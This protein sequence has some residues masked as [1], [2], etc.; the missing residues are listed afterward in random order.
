MGASGAVVMSFFGAL[1][2]SLTLLFQLNERGPMIGTPFIG[3]AVIAAVATIV[4]KS[5]GTFIKPDGSGR[6][7]MWSS[8]GEGAALFIVN[9]ALINIGQSDLVLPAMTLIVGLHFIPIA[10]YAPFRQLYVLAAIMMVAG[11]A[12][13]LLVQPLGGTM[14][15][16]TAAAALT[17]A[18]IAA[19]LRERWAKQSARNLIRHN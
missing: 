10:Y 15:G 2:A 13:L 16:F 5:P 3:F 4:A 1:F 11:V 18:S 6:V 9:E 8:V 14:A 17:M 7:I 12:G 19:V